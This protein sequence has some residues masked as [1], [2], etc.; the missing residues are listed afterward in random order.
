MSYLSV[1][2][3][4]DM[5]VSCLSVCGFLDMIVSLVIAPSVRMLAGH[6]TETACMAAP[7]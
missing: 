7:I 6:L 2:G 5:I 4:L 1:C 3:F